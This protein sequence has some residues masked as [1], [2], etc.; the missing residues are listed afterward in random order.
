MKVL[1]LFAGTRSVGREFQSRG[2]DVFSVEWDRSFQDI[3]LYADVGALT[4]EEVLRR[5]GRP[6]VIWASPDCSSY[7]VAALGHH[8]D[9][10]HSKTDYAMFC[11]RV[12]EHLVD[13]VL[14]LKPRFWF[15]ENPRAMMRKMPFIERLLRLGGGR[16][17]TITYC[18][19][20]E[21]RMK[22]TD[23]FTNHP[24]PQFRPSC[25]KGDPCH[26]RAPRGSKDAGTQAIRGS[27]DRARIPAALCRHIADVC[28]SPACASGAPAESCDTIKH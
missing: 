6:D 14:E 8:R 19:Y 28:E 24:D 27:R 20:G 7:S 9:G 23:I 5:F 12:N 1:E 3:D 17:H 10:T 15:V 25:R 11:D 18:Q 22:P 26:D 13:L 21:R 2:H 4:V 16:M